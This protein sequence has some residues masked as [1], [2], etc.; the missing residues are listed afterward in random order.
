MGQPRAPKMRPK[1]VPRR[2]KLENKNEDVEKEALE[3]RLRAVL[4]RSWVVLG[5]LLGV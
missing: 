1:W 4:G 5:A 3:D 2:T